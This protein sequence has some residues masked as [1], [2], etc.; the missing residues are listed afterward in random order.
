MQ[1]N[2]KYLSEK[3]SV[4]KFFEFQLYIVLKIRSLSELK[5]VS[6]IRGIIGLNIFQISD[7]TFVTSDK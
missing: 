6:E 5:T 2:P 1:Q 7:L 4:Q 3:K